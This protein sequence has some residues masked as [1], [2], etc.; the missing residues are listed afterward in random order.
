MEDRN[1]IL[2][3]AVKHSPDGR[4]EGWLVRFSNGQT[5]DLTG[6]YFTKNTNF[7]NSEDI[8]ILYQHGLDKDVGLKMQVPGKLKKF[9]EGLWI[10]GQLDLSDKYQSAVMKLVKRGALGWSSGTAPHL[11][12]TKKHTNGA[13]EITNWPIGLDGSLTPNP[14]EPTTIPKMLD[15]ATMKSLQATDLET[16][17]ESGKEATES[18]IAVDNLTIKTEGITIM[19]EDNKKEKETP[20]ETPVIDPAIKAMQDNT[21][22]LEAQLKS[23]MEIVENSGKLKDLGYI[24]PDD[25]DGKDSTK[26]LGDFLIAVKNDNQKRLKSVYGMKSQIEASGPDGGYLVPEEFIPQIFE[27]MKQDSGVIARVSN[28]LVSAPTGKYPALDQ[29]VAP[30]AGVGTSAFD[31]GMTGVA[32]AEGGTYTEDDIDFTMVEWKVNDAISGIVKVSRELSQD[33]PVIESLLTRMIAQVQQTKTEYFVLRGSG[34]NAPEGVLN[35]AAA[36]GIT[37]VTNSTFAYA[38]SLSMLSRFKPVG[39]QPVWIIHPSIMPDIGVFESSSGGGVFQANFQG[40]LGMSLLGYPII[41]SEHLPQANNSGCVILAD[42]SAYVLFNLGGMYV[43]FSE[44]A[45]FTSGYN[46]WR[47][48]QRM[49]GKLQLKSTITL[50][51]PQGSYTVSPIIYFND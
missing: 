5:T 24:A 26:S 51:D 7:G 30:T 43:D 44:H 9:D 14:A 23:V 2:G 19:S 17:L 3:G 40:A 37:P 35:S 12:Q 6:E 29:Y 25:T 15:I 18:V 20:E 49:D 32:R 39:G 36:I 48:G 28:Q 45:Y 10:E 33:A 50:A 41:M 38:D 34:V 4:I 11:V 31:G 1:F 47:F 16:L 13:K 8:N 46:A 22:K 21:A 42:L 27:V